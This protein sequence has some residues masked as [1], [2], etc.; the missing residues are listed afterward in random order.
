MKKYY[1]PSKNDNIEQITEKEYLSL[2]GNTEQ[3]PYVSKLYRELITIEEVPEDMRDEV[4][5][6]VKNRILRYDKYDEQPA[7]TKDIQEI[8]QAITNNSLTK[9]QAK[10]LLTDIFTIRDNA[11]DEVASRSINVFP[12]LK[13]DGSLIKAGTRINWEGMIK[14]AAVDLWD[15]PQNDPVDAPQL[16]EDL[17]Y[18]E[19]YRI[20]PET[21]T[22][23]T[24]FSKEELGWWDNKLYK[25]LLNANVYNPIQYPLGWEEVV[26][27][28][29]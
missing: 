27:E 21:I 20:I 24:A 5:A 18:F 14:R 25:S 22:V 28:G 17:N 9:G 2:I 19:G 8:I 23:G 4:Q 26:L 6:I 11:T 13:H 10:K 7:S 3:R 29:E 16:W 12:V 15:L 1:I